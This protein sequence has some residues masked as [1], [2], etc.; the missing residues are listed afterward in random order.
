[1]MSLAFP[2]SWRSYQATSRTSRA[3]QAA[4]GQT[5]LRRLKLLTQAALASLVCLVLKQSLCTLP[6]TGAKRIKLTEWLIH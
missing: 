6:N 4:N 1:M 5:P 2:K 3:F